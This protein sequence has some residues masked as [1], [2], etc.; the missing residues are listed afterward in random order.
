MRQFQLHPE[1]YATE[2]LQNR[3][4]RDDQLEANTL[5]YVHYPCF[6]GLMCAYLF[7]RWAASKHL[8]FAILPVDWATTKEI[9]VDEKGLKYVFFLDCAPSQVELL[10]VCEQVECVFV[11]DH[12]ASREWLQGLQH[13]N[14]VVKYSQ[15]SCASTLFSRFTRTV[16]HELL[17]TIEDHD[18]WKHENPTTRILTSALGTL[19]L[20]CDTLSA[21]NHAQALELGY[22][23]NLYRK[24]LIK[25][26]LATKHMM[27]LPEKIGLYPTVW[28]SS[29]DLVSDLGH[30]LAESD[31]CGVG[32][33]RRPIKTRVCYHLRSIREDVSA[34]CAS[35]G[36]GGHARAGGFTV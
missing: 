15:A 26:H 19:G 14:L 30:A 31:P 18:L 27:S 28:C 2:L 29:Y 3:T 24:K 23:V 32:V 35:M 33:V 17:P 22:A 4:I 1:L 20:T 13:Q 34:Y 7:N 12:H 10:R 36:G 16:K 6:D 25:D 8:E 11:F 21:W 5:C 9:T